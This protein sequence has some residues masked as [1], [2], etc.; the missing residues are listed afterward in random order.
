[1]DALDS[2]RLVSQRR[3]LG[4]VPG[5]GG[6]KRLPLSPLGGVSDDPCAFFLAEI[7]DKTQI[8]TIALAA[9]FEQLH[10]VI[11]GT[12][13]GMMLAN[14]PAVLIGRRL[15]DRLPVRPIRVAAAAVFATLAVLTL[16]GA[17]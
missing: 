9:R 15:A 13:C 11:I 1:M 4:I 17:G 7:G 10:P 6:R 2:C 3:D 16:L 14:I 8:A 12:T 5:Q